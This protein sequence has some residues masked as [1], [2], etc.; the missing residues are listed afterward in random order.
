MSELELCGV[1]GLKQAADT[2]DPKHLGIASRRMYYAAL[3][4]TC[5][6]ILATAPAYNPLVLWE[7]QHQRDLWLSVFRKCKEGK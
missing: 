1:K 2:P 5:W 3:Q 4:Y 6:N 7:A